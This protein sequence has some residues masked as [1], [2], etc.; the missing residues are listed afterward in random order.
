MLF[1]A[2]VRADEAEA[3]DLLEALLVFGGGDFADVG[4]GALFAGA[5]FLGAG[6][7]AFG[8]EAFD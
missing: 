8:D 6:F 2:L 1:F 5:R 4:K 3:V 7:F